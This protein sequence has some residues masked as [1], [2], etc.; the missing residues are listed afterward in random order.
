MV[1]NQPK[2]FQ[3]VTYAG[4]QSASIFRYSI[5]LLKSQ[6]FNGHWITNRI[7]FII[8]LVFD[9]G[10][11]GYG[12]AAPLAGFSQ[13]SLVECE[14]LLR[15]GLTQLSTGNELAITASAAKFALECAL[16]KISS[17]FQ[18]SMPLSVPLLVGDTTE[19]LD[20]YHALD[21]PD[22]VKLKVA[23]HTVEHDI[24]NIQSLLTLNKNIGFTLDANRAWSKQQA[25]RFANLCPKKS[26]NYIEEPCTNF[27]DS[28][29]FSQET[30]LGIAL[31]ETLQNHSFKF[32]AD[33]TIKALV[34][35]PTI[36]GSF[37]RCLQFVEQAKKANIPCYLSSAFESSFGISQLQ[38]LAKKWTP[39]QA[40]GFD[41]LDALTLDLLSDTGKNK[42]LLSLQD[43]EFLC[44][45]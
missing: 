12:E 7:G 19:M 30:G 23:R 10:T 41:T 37:E 39:K 15:L 33:D 40:S 38:Q 43:L 20:K 42:P 11:K 9:D 35:K 5:P 32:I 25:L 21:Y 22:T 26:I 18:F 13:E 45:Y 8:E 28:L 6:C 44:Q 3:K 17:E 36:I 24:K 4:I 34:I 27:T 14:Q 1:N 2:H 29:L 31:D 16:A